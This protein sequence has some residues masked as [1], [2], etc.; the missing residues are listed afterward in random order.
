[1]RSGIPDRETRAA[2]V[3]LYTGVKAFTRALGIQTTRQIAVLVVTPA[4]EVLAHVSG[5]YAAEAAASINKVL[6]AGSRR[7]T[8]SYPVSVDRSRLVS[9][10][11]PKFLESYSAGEL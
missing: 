1:M 10:A 11:T 2:T 9:W 8:W 7:T 4:G 5:R 6:D 3:T